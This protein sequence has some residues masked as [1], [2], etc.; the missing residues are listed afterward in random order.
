M[1]PS[2]NSERR[3]CGLE[4]SQHTPCREMFDIVDLPERKMDLLDCCAG[5]G[6]SPVGLTD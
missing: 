4:S 2:S 1:G 6:Q 5:Q 3:A